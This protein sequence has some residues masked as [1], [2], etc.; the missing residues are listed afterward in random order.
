[1]QGGR[2][3]EDDGNHDV[4]VGGLAMVDLVPVVEGGL[5]PQPLVAE[6][7]LQSGP[8]IRGRLESCLQGV[9]TAVLDAQLEPAISVVEI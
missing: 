1:M 8:A 2:V 6:S 5:G 9:G 3:A 4:F 7:R